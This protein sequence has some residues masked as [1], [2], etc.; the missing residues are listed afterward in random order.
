MLQ[1]PDHMIVIPVRMRSEK[2]AQNRNQMPARIF[3]G[4]EE[5]VNQVSNT[6]QKQIRE[7]NQGLE[8]QT[9]GNQKANEHK[10]FAK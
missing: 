4:L 9:S 5:S 10:Y 1:Y 8:I 2:D 6:E 7:K 3:I